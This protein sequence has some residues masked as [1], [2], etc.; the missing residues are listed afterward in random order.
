VN[1]NPS[2]A[3]LVGVLA[4]ANNANADAIPYPS[5]GIQNPVTYTFTAASTGNITAYF[6]GSTAAYTNDLGM[7]LNSASSGV[8]GLNK[9]TPRPMVKV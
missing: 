2:I 1:F 3:T 9:F 7:L 6:Y 4:L 8:E 5:P